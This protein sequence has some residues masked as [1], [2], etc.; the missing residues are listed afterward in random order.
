MDK[1]LL[2][3]WYLIYTIKQEKLREKN[4]ELLSGH[5]FEFNKMIFKTTHN[6]SVLFYYWSVIFF[7]GGWAIS[8]WYVNEMASRADKIMSHIYLYV[9]AFN[10][11]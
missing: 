7:L 6:C 8:P 5:N 1:I 3:K 4:S 10:N 9:H 2:Y 11:Q